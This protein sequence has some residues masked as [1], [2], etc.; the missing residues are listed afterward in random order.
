ML[1][2]ASILEM[3]MVICFGISWPINIRKAWKARTAKGT[4]VM[5]YFF[6]FVGYIAGIA[7]KFIQIHYAL[8][9][10]GTAQ[11]WTEVVKWYVMFFY[12]LN[13]VMVFGGILIWFRNRVLD[14][15]AEK[16]SAAG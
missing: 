11:S 8:H 12:F 10:A 16:A 6:I 15:Q 1:T 7:G 4:S 5:F 2:T 14:A 13:A 9:V 3:I